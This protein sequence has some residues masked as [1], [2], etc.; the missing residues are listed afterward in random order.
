MIYK[1][2]LV[3]KKEQPNVKPKYYENFVDDVTKQ[4]LEMYPNYD[5]GDREAR[6]LP[7]EEQFIYTILSQYN[8]H[9]NSNWNAD[10][11][12][13]YLYFENVDGYTAF[14]LRYG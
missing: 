11:A 7:F 5:L 4:F 10:E 2:L 13:G 1:T 8:A 14:M 3:F 6:D 9:R 12:N